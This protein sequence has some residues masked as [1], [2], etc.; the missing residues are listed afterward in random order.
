M[1]KRVTS[2]SLTPMMREELT[3]L[4]ESGEYASKSDIIRDAFRTYLEHKPDKRT[5]IA[6]ELY[7]KER[8][9]LTRAAEIAGLDTESF[10][11]ILRDRGVKLRT[12]AGT[13][14]EMGEGLKEL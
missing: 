13:W 12:Y 8:V 14:K 5:L 7:R 10:K 9:S 3:A 11:E 1:E 4:M 6:V 2:F